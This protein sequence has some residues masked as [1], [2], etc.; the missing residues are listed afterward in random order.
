[1]RSK[2]IWLVTAGYAALALGLPLPAGAGVSIA[3]GRAAVA[4][5]G[6]RA[7]KDRSRPFPCM[8]SPCGCGSAEQCLRECCCHSVEERREWAREHG[9]EAELLA[10]LERRAAGEG[11][12]PASRSVAREGCCSD[13]ADPAPS[14][15]AAAE[16]PARPVREAICTPGGEAAVT[17]RADRRGLPVKGDA[18]GPTT[19]VAAAPEVPGARPVGDA[20]APRVRSVT[21]RALLACQGM[22]AEW[23]S[24]GGTLPPARVEAGTLPAPSGVVELHDAVAMSPARVPESPP[25]EAG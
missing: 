1:M 16:D 25:P 18:D 7:T 19:V 10:A 2:L 23:V 17:I 13:A 4:A 20:P 15:C 12:R 24:V 5:A 8:N 6:L 11:G 14:C 21:L 22:V 9:L 3:R